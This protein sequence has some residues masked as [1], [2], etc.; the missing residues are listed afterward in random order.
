MKVRGQQQ[1]PSTALH[2]GTHT[3]RH[4]QAGSA[5]AAAAAATAAA[6]SLSGPHSGESTLRNPSPPL[7]PLLSLS[8]ISIV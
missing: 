2:T 3:H 7:L 6:V 1:P 5:A 4:A 8:P